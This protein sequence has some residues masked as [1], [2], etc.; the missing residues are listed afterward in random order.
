MKNLLT[1]VSSLAAIL[2]LS[3][4]AVAQDADPPSRVARI[5]YINGPVSFEPASVDQWTP[6]SL[7]YPMTTGDN[8]YT[9]NGGRAVL[10][11]G[12]NSIRL[13]SGT[14]FQFVNLSDSVV[15]TSINEGNLSLYIRHLFEGESWEVD[16]PNGSVT[17]LRPGKYRID[18]DTSRNATMV[19]V[20]AGDVEVTANNQSFPLHSGQTAYFDNSGNAPDVQAANQPDDFDSFVASRNRLEEVPPP[21]YVSPDMVGYE[22]LNANGDWRNT[23]EYGAVWSTSRRVGLPIM[24]ATGPGS[25]LGA[26]RGLTM[27]PG[28][29]HRSITDAG[30]MSTTGG[31]GVPVPLP[32]ACTTL[33]RWSLS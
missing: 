4:I 32:R 25:T 27:H 1:W 12:Q 3:G 18:T 21:Q 15:Q 19:T 22:D 5:A 17:L 11:I 33:P 23:S 31:A 10:R 24:T 30:P 7:N 28:A 2:A 6:A 14:N 8:L 20:S 16:T 9:D 29:S 13:N 26:G